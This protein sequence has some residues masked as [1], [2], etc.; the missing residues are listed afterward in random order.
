MM[1]A[2]LMTWEAARE[3]SAAAGTWWECTEAGAQMT[4]RSLCTAPLPNNVSKSIFQC[5]Q[6]CQLNYLLLEQEAT[7]VL[8]FDLT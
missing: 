8:P 7:L 6:V 5:L 4:R 1:C 2:P 3:V